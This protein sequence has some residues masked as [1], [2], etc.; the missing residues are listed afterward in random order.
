MAECLSSPAHLPGSLKRSRNEAMACNQPHVFGAPFG[1]SFGYHNE[2]TP[3]QSVEDTSAKRAKRARTGREEPGFG[4]S[5][6]EAQFH[7]HLQAQLEALQAQ[8]EAE[9]HEISRRAEG[10][11]EMLQARME[12][13][14]AEMTRTLEETREENRILKRAVQMLNGKQRE[15]ERKVID[16]ER[17]LTQAAEYVRKL[18]QS[19]YALRVHLEQAASSSTFSSGPP[20]VY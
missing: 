16:H 13:E 20:D 10:Q 3:M 6:G 7:R 1:A 17:S 8:H 12:G 11:V 4:S 18:E 14:R 19:N 5:Q 2:N 9:K 15:A